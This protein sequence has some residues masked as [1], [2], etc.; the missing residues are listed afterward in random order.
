L[1][2]FAE[3]ERSFIQERTIAGLA[4]VKA[5]GKSL[6]RPRVTDSTKARQAQALRD[7]GST[8]PE[9][10]T[11]LNVSIATVYRITKAPAKVTA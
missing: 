11:V 7:A 8:I 1:A 4:A 10:A 5:Q 6:G 3:M 9:I 2:I